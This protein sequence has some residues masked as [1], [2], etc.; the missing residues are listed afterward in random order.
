[1]K[2]RPDLEQARHPSAHLGDAV[3]GLG[4]LG[5]DPQE[6]RL[7]GSVAPD[8]ADGLALLDLERDVV[9]R[10]ERARVLPAADPIGLPERPCGDGEAHRPSASVRSTWRKT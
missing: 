7:A 5:E 9:E 2:A 10:T 1:M 6:R 4:D 3:G 8:H